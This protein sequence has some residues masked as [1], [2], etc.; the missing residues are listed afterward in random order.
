[1]DIKHEEQRNK[2]SFYIEVD[3][4]RVA[5]MTYTKTETN[6]M[7][8][9]HTEVGDSLRGTGS[10]KKLVDAGVQYARAHRLKVMP[11]CPFAK[12]LFEKTPAYADVWM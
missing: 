2:G 3:G 7:I 1:M 9:D 11:L 5:E 4:K 8:I 6:V 12:A 10:G